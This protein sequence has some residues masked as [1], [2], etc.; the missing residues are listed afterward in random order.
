MILSELRNYLQTHGQAAIHD[1]AVYFDSDPEA[2]RGMLD[3]LERRGKVQ[4]LAAGTPC[5]GGCSK[6]DP[7]TVEIYR[8]CS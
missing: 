4:K 6:C 5:G 2:I 3:E 1:L 8:W 7:D